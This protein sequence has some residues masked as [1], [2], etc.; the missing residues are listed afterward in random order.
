MLGISSLKPAIVTWSSDRSIL[1]ANP[2]IAA[3]KTRHT[4]SW[5]KAYL[6]TDPQERDLCHTVRLKY[7]GSRLFFNETVWLFLAS[8]GDPSGTQNTDSPTLSP[9]PSTHLNASPVNKKHLR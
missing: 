3:A 9:H 6:P 4:L 1:A 2:T 7:A 8:S 5:V